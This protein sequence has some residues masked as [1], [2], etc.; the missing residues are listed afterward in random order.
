M[1]SPAPVIP[2]RAFTIKYN[3]IS[4][5]LLSKAH[6]VSGDKREEVVALWDTGASRTCISKEVANELALTPTGRELIHTP[7][8]SEVVNT[9]LAD[10]SLPNKVKVE[11]VPVCDSSIGNQGIGAIIGMDIISLGD[12]VVCNHEGKT[13]FSFRFPSTGM[14]DFVKEINVQNAIGPKHGPGKRRRKQ[15]KR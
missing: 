2:A 11:Q 12:F 13:S 8:G 4:P 9:Y 15:K 10:L 14:I 6:V 5:R 3:N 7:S 1:A